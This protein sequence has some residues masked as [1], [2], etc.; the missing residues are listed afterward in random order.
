MSAKRVTTVALLV[1]LAV[2][3][4]T[5][6]LYWPQAEDVQILGAPSLVP[7][8]GGAGG[9]SNGATPAPPSPTAEVASVPAPVARVPIALVGSLHPKEAEFA[10]KSSR[11]ASL[12]DQAEAYAL[13]YNCLS[14]D[15]MLKNTGV[16]E[17]RLSPS[18]CGLAPG[19]YA[20]RETRRRLIEARVRE[21]PFGAFSQLLDEAPN[22]RF[23]AFA[24]DPRAYAE[25]LKEAAGSASRRPNQPL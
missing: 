25:L 23:K 19:T 3:S 24:D 13:A 2:A 10:Q 8:I 5:G 21:A 22:G 18:A 16:Q 9:V 17:H 4:Y 6:W 1:A 14:A 11:A 7:Q 20:E 15:S 12:K